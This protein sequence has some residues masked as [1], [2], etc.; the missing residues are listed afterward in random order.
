MSEATDTYDNDIIGIEGRFTSVDPTVTGNLAPRATHPALHT[1]N[2][3]RRNPAVRQEASRTQT[4]L[5]NMQ[6][7]EQYPGVGPGKRRDKLSSSRSLTRQKTASDSPG[8]VTS[9]STIPPHPTRTRAAVQKH[10]P[11][12]VLGPSEPT[13]STNSTPKSRDTGQ[14]RSSFIARMSTG[15]RMPKPYVPKHPP[16]PSGTPDHDD[17]GSSTN[18]RSTGISPLSLLR[19]MDTDSQA[20]QS[21]HGRGPGHS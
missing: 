6:F 1:P 17:S 7:F 16:L 13:S 15:G 9:T 10:D 19:R 5:D 12:A 18:T 20:P 2:G 3:T 4:T 11:K 8:R 21:K 14:R